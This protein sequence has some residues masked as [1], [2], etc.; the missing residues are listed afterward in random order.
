MLTHWLGHGGIPCFLP[1]IHALSISAP[2]VHRN[3]A[4]TSLGTSTRGRGGGGHGEHSIG[5]HDDRG[6]TPHV[7]PASIARVVQAFAG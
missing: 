5:N 6:A 7:V 2:K 3:G 4:L 1:P